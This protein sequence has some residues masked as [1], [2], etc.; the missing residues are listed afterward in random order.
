MA[1][2]KKPNTICRWCE[3]KY[4]ACKYCLKTQSWRSF[5]CCE[6]CHKK[7]IQAILDLREK[8]MNNKNNSLLSENEITN[9]KNMTS[10]EAL[11]QTKED[12]K[13]YIEENPDK[14]LSEV[15]DVVNKDITTRK[16]KNNKKT[17]T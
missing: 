8:E 9:I 5:C 15:L 16:K 6:E 7:Y 4:Y 2:I 11:S 1:N 17:L 10:E 3:K 14:S 13:D 12:L